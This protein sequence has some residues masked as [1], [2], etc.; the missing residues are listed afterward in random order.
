MENSWKIGI[1]K[2]GKYFDFWHVNHFLAGV[3]LGGLVIIFNI[4]LWTGFFVSLFLM[5]IWEAFEIV[6]KIKETEFN[7]AF[8][9]IFS[10]IAFILIIFLQENYLSEF[11]F[12]AVFYTSLF[13]YIFLELWG[14]RA[15]KIREKIKE[16]LKLRLLRRAKSR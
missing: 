13:L 11:Q 5:F 6:K 8:D 15:Y 4:E 1:W 14:F 9:V 16:K 12:H 2:E 7:M 10:V 3:L